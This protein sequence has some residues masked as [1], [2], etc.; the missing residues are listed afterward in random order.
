MSPVEEALDPE[1]ARLA[2]P[3]LEEALREADNPDNRLCSDRIL[4]GADS[5]PAVP[6]DGAAVYTVR[7]APEGVPGAAGSPDSVV[8]ADNF[9]PAVARPEADSLDSVVMVDSFRQAVEVPEVAGS[10]LDH[11]VGVDTPDSPRAAALRAS[12]AADNFQ[13]AADR[14]VVPDTAM[15]AGVGPEEAAPTHSEAEECLATSLIPAVGEC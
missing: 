4:P 1:V 10:N 5:D 2:V 14:V 3:D 15:A 9:L 11:L 12:A 6:L 13:E 7:T 8:T